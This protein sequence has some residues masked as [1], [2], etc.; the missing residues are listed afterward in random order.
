VNHPIFTYDTQLDQVDIVVRKSDSVVAS[1][2]ALQRSNSR[3]DIKAKL[4]DTAQS[5][6]PDCCI[7]DVAD[8]VVAVHGDD[9]VIHHLSQGHKVLS[10]R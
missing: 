3:A 7:I 10:V 1:H 9:E 8:E 4:A 5:D 2:R 6:V